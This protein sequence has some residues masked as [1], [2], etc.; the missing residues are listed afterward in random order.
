MF[1]NLKKTYQKV[2]S[3]VKK[4]EGLNKIHVG[5]VLS[6]DEN[7]LGSNSYQMRQEKTRVIN[8]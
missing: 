5:R 1:L 3:H 4:H 8:K 2:Q 7:A 6:G